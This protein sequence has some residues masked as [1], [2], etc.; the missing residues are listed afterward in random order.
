MAA[1]LL[2]PPQA[3]S[4]EMIA[5]ATKMAGKIMAARRPK[6]DKDSTVRLT[7]EMEVQYQSN[8]RIPCI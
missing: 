8:G 6:K 5:K 7:T 1:S 4:L 3:L 2:C